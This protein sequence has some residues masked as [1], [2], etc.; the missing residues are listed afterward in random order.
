MKTSNSKNGFTLVELIIV[1]A[2]IAILSG[3]ILFSVTQYINKGKDSNISGN[4]AVLIPAGETY[5]NIENAQAG[6]GY[7]GFC[8]P[9]ANS[10]LKNVIIQMPVNSL[11]YCYTT[12]P[13]VNDFNN[14]A[15]V[16]CTVAVG[17]G[18]WVA[19]ARELTYPANVYCVDSRGVKEEVKNSDC[20][21]ITSSGS[22]PSVT[23]QC[24]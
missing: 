14:P 12:W 5:Y 23:C 6:D 15:G 18:S 22:C 3:V 13:P 7:S 9:N 4:L 17:G 1:I 19:C 16:C 20:A 11:G 21:A 24:P 8:N 10:A 2:I